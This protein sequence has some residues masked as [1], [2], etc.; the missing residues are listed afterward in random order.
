MGES[1]QNKPLEIISGTPKDV[2]GLRQSLISMLS[3]KMGEGV[4]G[5]GGQM[6]AGL[7]PLQI[8]ASNIMSQQMYG[9]PYSG[10][11]VSGGGGGG[12]GNGLDLGNY[13]PRGKTYNGLWDDIMVDQNWGPSG[14]TGTNKFGNPYY[15]TFPSNPYYPGS[16]WTTPPTKPVFTPD[17]PM[18]PANPGAPPWPGAVWDEVSGSWR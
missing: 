15:E 18:N 12:G 10:Q 6:S 8:M 17:D 7:D 13:N 14:P 1:W 2:A 11:T 9:V 3:G 4:A 16:P 5:Y